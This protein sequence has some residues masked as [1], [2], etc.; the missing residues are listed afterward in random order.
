MTRTE[1][2]EL[3]ELKLTPEQLPEVQVRVNAILNGD[4]KPTMTQAEVQAIVANDPTKALFSKSLRA[5]R[6]DKGT[7]RPP[8]PTKAKPEAQGVLPEAAKAHLD[9]LRLSIIDK[10][11]AAKDAEYALQIAESDWYDYLNS[12]TRPGE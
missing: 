7:K 6:S 1:Q 5:P 2:A 11:R 4:A 8:K 3:N 12:L 10:W 9:K